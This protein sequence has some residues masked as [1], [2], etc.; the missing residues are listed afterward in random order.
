MR[1]PSPRKLESDHPL[2][3]P[4]PATTGALELL[5]IPG[6]SA[7]DETHLC[8]AETQRELLKGPVQR[9]KKCA[10]LSLSSAWQV[11]TRRQVLLHLEAFR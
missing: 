10:T 9:Q 6:S 4:A 3:Q 7:T 2:R 8:R 11:D 5:S 1:S